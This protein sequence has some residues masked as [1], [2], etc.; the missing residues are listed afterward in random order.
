MSFEL[1]QPIDAGKPFEGGGSRNDYSCFCHLKDRKGVYVFVKNDGAVLYVGEADEVNPGREGL[2]DRIPQHFTSGDTRGTFRKK[3]CK[4]NCHSKIC[5]QDR[6]ACASKYECSFRN[7]RELL[8]SSKIHVFVAYDETKC[9]ILDL[10]RALICELNPRYNES[11]IQQ[12]KIDADIS[13]Q[14]KKIR[15]QISSQ[16]SQ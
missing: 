15:N 16:H 10:E 14:V 6:R 4:K 13:D 8:K 7:F 5:P 1:L 9:R 12:E 11:E 2:R 3:Y